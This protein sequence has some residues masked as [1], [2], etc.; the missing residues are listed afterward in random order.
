M[1]ISLHGVARGPVLAGLL[2]VLFV[3]AADQ[4]LEDRAHGVV[5]EAGQLA[6]SRRRS[7]TG[8]R[9]EVDRRVEELLDQVAEGVGLGERGN[10]VAELEVVEDVLDV[11]R[12]AVEVGLEIGLELLLAGAGLAGRAA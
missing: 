11:G 6:R 10:L 7:S 9:A 4:F 12:E 1:A 8:L 5:V 2:V 3:E